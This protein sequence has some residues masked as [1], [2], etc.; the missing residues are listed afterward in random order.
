M[1][2]K[3]MIGLVLVSMTMVL[4]IVAQFGPWWTHISTTTTYNTTSTQQ[5]DY[6]TYQEISTSKSGNQVVIVT[7][8]YNNVDQRYAAGA[9][10]SALLMTMGALNILLLLLT[11]ILLVCCILGMI[12]PAMKKHLTEMRVRVLMLILSVFI[13]MTFVAFSLAL[14]GISGCPMLGSETRVTGQGQSQITFKFDYIPSIGLFGL[15]LASL[16]M[17]LGAYM[18]RYPVKPFGIQL[19]VQQ[20]PPA[21][22]PVQPVY[23]Y[24]AQPTPP[25]A[26]AYVPPPAQPAPPPP[27]PPI[28]HQPASILPPPP[29]P[30]PRY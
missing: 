16:F 27:P 3:T 12:M 24:P 22:Q 14:S 30:P 19:V 21:P 17:F 8:A 15:L 1:E 6:Y 13:F 29:P 11:I 28:A 10:I 18:F 20:V 5:L 25:P 7:N 26:P 2:K 9:T 23:A 4:L